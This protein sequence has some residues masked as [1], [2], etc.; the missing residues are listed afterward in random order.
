MGAVQI[1][2]NSRGVRELLRSRAVV[3][4]LRQVAESIA[5]QARAAGVRVEHVPGDIPLPVTVRVH[6]GGDRAIA[7]VI[8]DHPSGIAVEAKHRLLGRSLDSGRA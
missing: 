3:A 7:Q 4:A 5:D 8:L 6:G 1:K 2:L